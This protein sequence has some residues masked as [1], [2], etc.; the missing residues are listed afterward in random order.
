M[1]VATCA[2]LRMNGF[3][4]M[5]PGDFSQT[6]A[7]MAKKTINK[8]R[9]LPNFKR[10]FSGSRDLLVTPLH[11][12]TAGP[13]RHRPSPGGWPG[14]SPGRHRRWASQW[15]GF[16]LYGIS[17]EDCLRWFTHESMQLS[18]IPCAHQLPIFPCGCHGCQTSQISFGHHPGERGAPDQ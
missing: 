6:P 8:C 14:Q 5:V 12:P 9:T 15:A 13:C 1:W 18:R 11:G 4:K 7:C 3:D 16:R 10:C 17:L 2:C